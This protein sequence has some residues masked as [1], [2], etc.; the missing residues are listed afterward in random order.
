[1]WYHAVY[2]FTN[3]LEE[4]HTLSIFWVKEQANQVTSEKQAL[5]DPED[6]GSMFLWNIV[7]LLM[8]FTASS[9]PRG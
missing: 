4:E 5:L 3:V 2:K 7:K 9:H 8:D 6:G 1:M